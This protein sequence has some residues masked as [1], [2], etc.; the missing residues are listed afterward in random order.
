MVTS[1]TEFASS[2]HELSDYARGM[3]DAAG[4]LVM[5][6]QM[7]R[8][9]AGEMSAQEMRTAQVIL[10]WKRRELLVKVNPPPI[11]APRDARADNATE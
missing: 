9:H 7:I 1:P 3:R 10:A 4:L 2:P 8:L 11:D 6:P 5:S